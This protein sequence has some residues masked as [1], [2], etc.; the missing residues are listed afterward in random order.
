METC[1]FKGCCEIKG[2]D[3]CHVVFGRGIGPNDFTVTVFDDDG[4]SPE[5][6]LVSCESF[7]YPGTT[8]DAVIADACEKLPKGSVF[9]ILKRN[10]GS[11]IAWYHV[12]RANNYEYWAGHIPVPTSDGPLFKD[13]N[14]PLDPL[15]GCYVLARC[16]VV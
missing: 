15:R 11:E 10:D 3:R 7:P 6:G 16:R 9:E 1:G 14:A 5:H 8:I 2:H 4:N 13:E 12:R